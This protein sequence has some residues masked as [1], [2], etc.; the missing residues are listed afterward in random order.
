MSNCDVLEPYMET[1]KH[2]IRSTKSHIYI[3]IYIYI[4]WQ[5][6][7]TIHFNLLTSSHLSLDPPQSTI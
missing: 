5:Q 1:W 2:I 3:H 4:Y 7:F 6:K